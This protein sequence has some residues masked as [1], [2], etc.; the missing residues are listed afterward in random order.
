MRVISVFSIAILAVSIW[1][2]F[3]TIFHLNNENQQDTIATEEI[4]EEIQELNEEEALDEREKIEQEVKS[5]VEELV[6]TNDQAKKSV[7]K[8][9][10]STQTTENKPEDLVARASSPYND[11]LYDFEKDNPVSVD[12]LLDLLSLVE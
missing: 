7:D 1:S 9:T 11:I 5:K 4:T 12:D 8:V 3:F 6:Q 2:L 10:H